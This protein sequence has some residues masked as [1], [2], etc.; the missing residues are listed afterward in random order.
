MATVHFSNA[1]FETEGGDPEA[2][3]AVTMIGDDDHVAVEDADADAIPEDASDESGDG[4]LDDNYD[5]DYAH[6]VYD[7]DNEN[8]DGN[9]CDAIS[10]LLTFKKNALPINTC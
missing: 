7:G 2:A 1:D 5:Y 9:A 6:K 4:T 10:R 8:G 3:M